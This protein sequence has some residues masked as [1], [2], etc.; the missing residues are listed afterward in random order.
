MVH[1][2]VP[3]NVSRY[4]CGSTD[5]RVP[6]RLRR[7]GRDEETIPAPGM[8]LP[9][10]SGDLLVGRWRSRCDLALLALRQITDLILSHCRIGLHWRRRAFDHAL[11]RDTGDRSERRI[12]CGVLRKSSD[13]SEVTS[14]VTRKKSRGRVPGRRGP[15]G[16]AGATGLQ[17]PVGK[18]GRPGAAGAAPLSAGIAPALAFIAVDEQIDA[19]KRELDVQLRRM[20]QIQQQLDQLRAIV[21][22]L[23]ERTI[24]EA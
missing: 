12:M 22:Q 4:Y 3:V 17:G 23:A 13:S 1:L 7:T 24:A 6:T 5:T 14:M 20:A 2:P 10:L 19:M 9:L 11:R 15:R 16:P 18:R 21:R 8:H